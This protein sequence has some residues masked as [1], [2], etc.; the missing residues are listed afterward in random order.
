MKTSILTICVIA[1]MAITN[2][3][4]AQWSTAIANQDISTEV[5]I[6]IQLAS[7]HAL[8]FGIIASPSVASTLIVDSFWGHQASAGLI[9]FGDEHF[10]IFQVTGQANRTYALTLPS[11]PVELSNG[12]GGTMTVTDF[13]AY[14]ENGSNNQLNSTLNASGSEF[15]RVGATLNIGANQPSGVYLGSYTAT[16]AYN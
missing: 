15:V 7:T 5:V 2:T 4:K 8:R 6:P 12:S 3:A 16:A 14:F 11:Q 1:M 13:T 10:G 9:F